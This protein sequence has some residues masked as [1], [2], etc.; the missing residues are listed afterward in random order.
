MIRR[1]PRST[2][3]PYTTLFRSKQLYKL[4]IEREEFLQE[5]KEQQSR[6]RKLYQFVVAEHPG[7]PWARR[8]ESELRTGY[9]ITF[10][11]YFW[12]PR[13]TGIRKEIKFP[14]P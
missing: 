10:G 5:L 6:S 3:F 4:K 1:P 11:S 13:Y 14:K 9:G 2:L 8:A 7:T 12:D